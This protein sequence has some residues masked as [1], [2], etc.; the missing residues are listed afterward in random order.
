MSYYQSVLQGLG[1]KLDDAAL[2][3][4]TNVLDSSHR[5]HRRP[6]AFDPITGQ[7]ICSSCGQTKPPECFTTNR[8]KVDGRDARCKPCK[9]KAVIRARGVA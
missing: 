6:S 7:R 3:S 4:R 8:N 2:A 9:S 1:I 5:P